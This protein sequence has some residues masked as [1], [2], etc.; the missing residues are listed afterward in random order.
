MYIYEKNTLPHQTF[1][2]KEIYKTFENLTSSKKN[3]F[4]HMCF[5]FI[6]SKRNNIKTKINAY[7][8]LFLHE[9]NPK[10]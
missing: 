5:L 9:N 3:L 4:I 7:F 2:K 10:K 6:V 1:F 8:I